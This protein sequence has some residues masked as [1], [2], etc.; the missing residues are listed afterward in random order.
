MYWNNPLI[1]AHWPG[2]LDPIQQSL[3]NGQ[4]C[5]FWNPHGNFKQ[6]KT[7]QTLT[8]LSNWANSWLTQDGIDGFIAE[9]KNHYDIA[10]LVKL[11]IWI[12][13]IREQGIVKPMLFLHEADGT[14]LTGTGESRM[15][16]LERIPEITSEIG[17][18]HV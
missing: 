12:K 1:E 10:N 7:N 9:V 16:C 13:D 14:W 8:D 4:H 2:E 3:H 6:C 11:N 5:L 17:R 15:R 18:A